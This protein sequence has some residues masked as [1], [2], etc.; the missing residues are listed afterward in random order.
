MADVHLH[1]FV[2]TNYAPTEEEAAA[3]GITD[4]VLLRMDLSHNWKFEGLWNV[5]GYV[6][7]V[8]LFTPQLICSPTLSCWTNDCHTRQMIL[9]SISVCCD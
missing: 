1:P 9:V 7:C 2:T 6:L 4:K 8:R 5:K 3:D